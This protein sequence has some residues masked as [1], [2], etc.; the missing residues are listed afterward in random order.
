MNPK[1]K[2]LFEGIV[3]VVLAVVL[4]GWLTF[5]SFTRG[6][7]NSGSSLPAIPTTAL[8]DVTLDQLAQDLTKPELFYQVPVA[9]PSPGDKD[10]GTLVQ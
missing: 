4:F 9:E 3:I 5:R 2:S 1:E 6:V 10:K 7:T 8:T